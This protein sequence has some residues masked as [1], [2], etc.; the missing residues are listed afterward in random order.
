MVLDV[1]WK[2]TYI[3]SPFFWMKPFQSILYASSSVLL[4][5]KNPLFINKATIKSN[6]NGPTISCGKE[7]LFESLCWSK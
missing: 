4:R 1:V 6:P 7:R 3:Q 5:Y 2:M